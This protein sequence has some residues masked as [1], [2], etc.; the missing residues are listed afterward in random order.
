[1]PQTIG[2]TQLSL[3]MF[4]DLQDT[5]SV[6]SMSFSAAFHAPKSHWLETVVGL[7]ARILVY[8]G[9]SHDLLAKYAPVLSCWK[10]LQQSLHPDVVGQKLLQHLP[11][12]GMTRNG[13]LFRLLM[14][15]RRIS[16][17]DGFVWATP[18]AHDHQNRQPPTQDKLH[19]TST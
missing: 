18:T 3:P 8:G 19:I 5:N 2:A 9:S 11:K 17:T 15:E 6:M 4:E 7:K 13:G 12:W 1:M 10:M 16:A 14:P